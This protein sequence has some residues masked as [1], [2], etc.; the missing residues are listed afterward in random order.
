MP[1][2]KNRIPEDVEEAILDLTL[3]N[4]ALGQKRV[5]HELRGL[6]HLALLRISV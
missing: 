2:L 3:E 4:P 5:S 1:N 6:L